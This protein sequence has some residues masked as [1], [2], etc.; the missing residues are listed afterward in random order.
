MFVPSCMHL[1]RGCVPGLH[2]ISL[3]CDIRGPWKRFNGSH[4][5]ATLRLN[6]VFLSKEYR[7]RRTITR[8]YPKI[9]STAWINA[10]CSWSGSM[11]KSP[12][13][14]CFLDLACLALLE[15][16]SDVLKLSPRGASV[17][18]PAMPSFGEKLPTFAFFGMTMRPW[19]GGGCS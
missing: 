10:G 7:K 12:A 11:F 1:V 2:A 9:Y 5:L 17:T 18:T 16:E 3:L 4:L 6:H 8:I 19:I 14:V 15:L 13:W